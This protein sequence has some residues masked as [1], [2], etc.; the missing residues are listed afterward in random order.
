MKQFI[1][2]TL[3]VLFGACKKA[4]R[5]QLPQTVNKPLA[6][7]NVLILGNSITYAPASLSL[8][9]PGSWGMAATVADSDYVHILTARFK[10]ANS[11]CVVTSS[12]IS[13]FESSWSSYNIDANLHTFRD[14]NPDLVIL[15]IGENVAQTGLDTAS[16]GAAYKALV[17]YFG[18]KPSILG[19]GSFWSRPVTDAVMAK[20][21]DFFSL[22]SL[23]ND[24]TNYSFGLWTDPGIQQHPSNKGMRL[25]ADSIWAHVNKL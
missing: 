13:V 9:W 15:R 1:L 2:I 12:N 19:V 10:K 14:M 22:A 3:V 4:Y 7:K 21:G 24:G 8:G 20:Y 5:V 23:G 16:F 6:F 18:T 17:T 25:I 11:D